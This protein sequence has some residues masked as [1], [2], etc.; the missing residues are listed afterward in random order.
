MSTSS[1]K[2]LLLHPHLSSFILPP[3]L[4]GAPA[5]FT[6][7]PLI[8][9]VCLCIPLPLSSLIWLIFTLLLHLFLSYV[10]IANN[11]AI[12]APICVYFE[13]RL[14]HAY[15]IYMQTATIPFMQV[16][17]QRNCIWTKIHLTLFL[18]GM[19]TKFTAKVQCCNK[20]RQHKIGYKLDVFCHLLK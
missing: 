9:S 3:L 1:I 2:T 14:S 11:M 15:L 12:P 10:I 19:W 20:H 6:C 17:L 13:K 4:S 7:C 16:H 8:L 5:L 18:H